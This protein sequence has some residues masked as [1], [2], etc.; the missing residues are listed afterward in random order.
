MKGIK[1]FRHQWPCISFQSTYFWGPVSLSSFPLPTGAKLIAWN[2]QGLMEDGGRGKPCP[3]LSDYPL[4]T[5]TTFVHGTL[6]PWGKGE[7]LSFSFLKPISLPVPQILSIPA[8]RNFLSTI[9]CFILHLAV[10]PLPSNTSKFICIKKKK[11]KKDLIL[12][13]F[14]QMFF[15][16]RF[17]VI[18]FLTFMY[19]AVLALSWN[20]FLSNTLT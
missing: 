1:G 8:P 18:H 17:F 2:I 5:L 16:S 6:K 20:T 7:V 14:K 4:E 11:E 19:L 3:Y 10:S 12:P 9:F 13:V 15:P